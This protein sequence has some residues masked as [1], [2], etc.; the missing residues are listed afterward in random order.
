MSTPRRLPTSPYLLRPLRTYEEARADRQAAPEDA[1]AGAE[2]D[3][4]PGRQTCRQTCR[5]PDR[6]S[7]DSGGEGG[8][9]SD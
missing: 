6:R 8:G 1:A 3:S 7:G 9:K 4:R 5:H 2:L